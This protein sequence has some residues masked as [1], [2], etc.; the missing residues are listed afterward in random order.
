MNGQRHQRVGLAVAMMA[1]AVSTVLYAQSVTTRFSSRSITTDDLLEA[2]FTFSGS[3]EPQLPQ[4][5]PDWKMV[6]RSERQSSSSSFTVVINGKMVRNDSKK[7][8]TII[9]T[10]QPLRAGLLT[11]GTA[12]LV[13]N[14]QVLASSRSAEIHVRGVQAHTP[15]TVDEPRNLPR[16]SI[17]VVPEFKRDWYFVGEP[18]VATWTLLVQKGQRINEPE[19]EE[20]S[21]SDAIQRENILGDRFQEEAPT[22]TLFGRVFHRVPV[23]RE[24]WTVIR[25]QEKV[26]I[27]GL[28]VRVNTNPRD[29]FSRPK[30]LK[31]QPVSLELRRVPTAGRPADYRE[32]TI[33]TFT[34]HARLHDDDASGRA[35]L[36][37]EI[38]GN[39]SLTTIDPP[40]LANLA[41]A[42]ARVLP[43]DDRDTIEKD[44][45]GIHGKRIFQYILT[46]KRAGKIVVPPVR[47]DFFNPNTGQFD[48]ANSQQL[49]W[50]P[51]STTIPTAKK[52]NQTVSGQDSDPSNKLMPL[53]HE[54]DLISAR[55][56]PVHES[57]WYQLAM[58]IPFLGFLILELWSV[59]VGRRQARSG[60]I[61]AKR[62][63]G[64]GRKR[65]RSAEALAEQGKHTECYGEIARTLREYVSNRLGVGLTGLT[66]AQT[67][68][69]LGAIGLSADVIDGLIAELESCDFA[70]FAPSAMDGVS[71]TEALKRADTILAALEGASHA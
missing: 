30:T 67:H 56:T 68:E 12:S 51:R 59:M 9:A 38:R 29:F 46:P 6:R 5:G 1:M 66:N 10:L 18:I 37:I 63:L 34:V 44:R 41:G 65:L 7:E 15:S 27:P 24:I 28:R 64:T 45:N 43:S 17:I 52:P 48:H 53:E 11:V 14:G 36:E 54:S 71:V 32:G 16:D 55:R 69:K 70:R 2:H 23:V 42:D 31:S 33:G 50:E 49:T 22:K 25:P 26:T 19:I 47:L 8:R 13:K 61:R 20:I 35:I 3:G 40:S 60:V 57:L 4:F 39:G 62:A 58:S 21:L